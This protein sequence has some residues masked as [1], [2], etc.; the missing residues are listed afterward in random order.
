MGKRKD[1]DP[2]PVGHPLHGVTHEER[3]A[4]IRKQLEEIF[5]FPLNTNN[6]G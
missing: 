3:M 6:H 5:D 4:Y 2:Y 1:K